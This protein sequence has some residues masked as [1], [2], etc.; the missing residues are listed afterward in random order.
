MHT[1]TVSV[2]GMTCDHCVRAVTDELSQLEPVT[3]VKVQLGE[4]STVTISSDAELS[5][6]DIA[7][8]VDEAGY[9]VV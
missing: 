9:E 7:A 6:Q 5:A 1:T 8:A 4:P 2:S 3:D